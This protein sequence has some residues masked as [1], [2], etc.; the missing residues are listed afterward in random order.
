MVILLQSSANNAWILVVLQEQSK[1]MELVQLPT[2]TKTLESP[3]QKMECKHF[4]C[5]CIG[6]TTEW[7]YT[8]PLTLKVDVHL[9]T[10]YIY[11]YNTSLIHHRNLI[12]HS[13]GCHL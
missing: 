9:C 7:I 5:L 2:E 6:F 13:H 1:F 12:P 4:L 8:L 11:M 10:L 3:M